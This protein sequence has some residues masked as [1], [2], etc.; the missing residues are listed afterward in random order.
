VTASYS[1]S[2][3][4]ATGGAKDLDCYIWRNAGSSVSN[5]CARLIVEQ[6]KR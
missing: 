5:Y 1:N 4:A 2:Y 6:V 3:T